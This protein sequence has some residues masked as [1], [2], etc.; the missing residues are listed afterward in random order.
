MSFDTP[1]VEYLII[2]THA[3]SWILFLVMYIFNIPLSFIDRIEAGLAL[4][5]LPFAY[6]LG[7]LFDSIVQGALDKY[8]KGIRDLYFYGSYEKYKD[9]FIALVSPTLY[10]AYEVRV[11]RVRILGAAIFNWPLL[12]IS[13]LLYFQFSSLKENLIIVLVGAS[14]TVASGFAWGSLYKRAYKYRKNACDVIRSE[15]FHAKG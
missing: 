1:L 13:L 11:R 14:L 5:F 15:S 6:L 10:T 2:G 8:R 4:L 12:T 3:S 9:E 7:M